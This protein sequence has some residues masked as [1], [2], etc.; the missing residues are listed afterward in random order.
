METPKGM[1][2]KMLPSEREEDPLRLGRSVL[3]R[4]SSGKIEPNWVINGFKNLEVGEYVS[5][6]YP[7]ELASKDVALKELEELNPP[8]K[9]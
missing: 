4:R 6:F 2:G 7:D 8:K 9:S 3:V 5:V 1:E